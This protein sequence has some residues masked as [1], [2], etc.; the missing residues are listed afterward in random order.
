MRLGLQRSSSVLQSSQM[1]QVR[2]INDASL[3][4]RLLVDIKRLEQLITDQNQKPKASMELADAATD[5]VTNAATDTA[6]NVAKDI[7]QKETDKAVEE[8]RHELKRM[9]LGLQRSSSVLESSQ[10]R[11]VRSINDASL[12]ER[13][14]VDIKRLKQ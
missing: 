14:L 8:A 13:L 11:Q 5:A 1:R 4:E 2:S 6:T 9:Q 10:T 3:A 7:A 12:A